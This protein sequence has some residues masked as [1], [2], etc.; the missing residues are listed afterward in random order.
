MDLF[1]SITSFEK[2][3]TEAFDHLFDLD[4]SSAKVAKIKSN[5]DSFKKIQLEIVK[6]ISTETVEYQILLTTFNEISTCITE[7]EALMV[8]YGR[9]K[10]NLNPKNKTELVTKKTEL[11]L[12]SKQ[13]ADSAFFQHLTNITESEYILTLNSKSASSGLSTIYGHTKNVPENNVILWKGMAALKYI[14]DLK[15]PMEYGELIKTFDDYIIRAYAAST[16]SG[17]NK[18]RELLKVVKVSFI[19]I[20]DKFD[21][22][23]RLYIDVYNVSSMFEHLKKSV[24]ADKAFVKWATDNKIA[25]TRQA[26][27]TAGGIKKNL[28]ER[29]ALSK[30]VSEVVDLM[31]DTVAK[32][33]DY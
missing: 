31:M 30:E 7:Y 22:F 8:E 32:L 1:D 11:R 5:V 33:V 14:Q 25:I 12:K 9:L 13:I 18:P 28:S 21:E 4:L 10:V 3:K 20:Y 24:M 27:F 6:D 16:R 15:M 2:K 23:Y 29:S 26:K 17:H 19:Q